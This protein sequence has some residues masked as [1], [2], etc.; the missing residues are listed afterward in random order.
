MRIGNL[1]GRGKYFKV[2]EN[3]TKRCE[4]CHGGCEE[5][6]KEVILGA[7]FTDADKKTKV[8]RDDEYAVREKKAV[9]VANSCPGG[10]KVMQKNGFIRRRGR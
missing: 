2:C 4:G 5:Y 7:I 9:R 3:C 10:K 1:N 6:A 8:K